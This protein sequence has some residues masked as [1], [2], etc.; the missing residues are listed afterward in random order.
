MLIEMPGPG[1]LESRQAASLAGLAPV[2][3]ESGH[4]K[5]K[6]FTGGGRAG[7]RQALSMP[8]LAALRFNAGLKAK[9]QR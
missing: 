6:S 1:P 9:Y 3:R 5:G 2:T 8:A 7:W 4:C